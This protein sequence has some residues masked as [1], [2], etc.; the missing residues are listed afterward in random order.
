MNFINIGLIRL[1]RN[2]GIFLS[3]EESALAILCRFLSRTVCRY[4]TRCTIYGF[5]SLDR[6]Y[7][8][9][10]PASSVHIVGV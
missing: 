8:V 1:V 7:T 10:I 2:A 3:S 4:S 6:S 9:Y 5:P